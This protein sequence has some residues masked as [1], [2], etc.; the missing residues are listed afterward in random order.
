MNCKINT[1]TEAFGGCG[2]N[3]AY[4]LAHN[5]STRPLLISVTG[6]AD[7]QRYVDHLEAQ[8]ISCAGLMRVDSAYSARAIIITDRDGHQFTA[9]FPGD[10]PGVERWCAHL[11]HLPLSACT[12]LVQAP[13]PPDLM[14]ASTK[15][16]AQLSSN[17]LKICCPG[18]YADQLRPDET[19]ELI[20]YTDWVIGNAYEIN[21]LQRACSMQDKLI[22]QTNGAEEI[23]IFVPGQKPQHV[24]VPAVEENVDPTGCGDAFLAS[25]A[26]DLVRQG[27]L[28]NPEALSDAV[29]SA[30]SNA[31]RCLS[32]HGGQ[33]HFSRVDSTPIHV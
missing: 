10:V 30:C 7:D 4:N 26:N 14:I 24:A 29:Q 11:E 8:G 1:L 2:G 16:A 33:Q 6:T 28:D 21:H 3:I 9:F 23:Q 32:F 13:F 31:A 12:V 5:G 27:G 19:R 20:S 18:Q 15:Y 25:I 17:P 22:L